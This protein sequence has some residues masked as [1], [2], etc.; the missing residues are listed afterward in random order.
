[1]KLKSCYSIRFFLEMLSSKS[2]AFF[3]LCLF[4]ITEDNE[5]Q[6]KFNLKNILNNV[7]TKSESF[8]NCGPSTDVLQIKTLSILPDPLNL[9]GNITL[10]AGITLAKNVTGPL[11]VFF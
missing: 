11:T 1:M 6:C 10:S 5:V 2:F 8:E 7:E 4:F 3:I 9:Q